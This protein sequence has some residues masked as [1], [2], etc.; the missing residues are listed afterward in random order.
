M[1]FYLLPQ[2]IKI[3]FCILLPPVFIDGSP[4]IFLNQFDKNSHTGTQKS[5]VMQL[6][7]TSAV[8]TFQIAEVSKITKC[9]VSSH[10]SSVNCQ[11]SIRISITKLALVL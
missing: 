8:N 6:N 7:C 2:V 9:S 5:H 1:Q 10:R 3:D 4:H 11:I